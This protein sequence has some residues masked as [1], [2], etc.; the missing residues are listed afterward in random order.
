MSA[1]RPSAVSAGSWL[2]LLALQRVL[3][4]ADGVLDLAFDLLALALGLDLLVAQQLADAFLDLA[5][6]ALCRTLGAIRVYA[7]RV[8]L[9]DDRQYPSA[10]VPRCLWSEVPASRSPRTITEFADPEGG[11]TFTA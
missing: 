8:F 6:Y 1:D 2:G 3:D 11:P 7:L 5:A 9:P 4:A 10:N